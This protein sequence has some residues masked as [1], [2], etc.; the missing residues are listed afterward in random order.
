[1]TDTAAPATPRWSEYQPITQLVP[2]DRNAKDHDQPA[3][4]RSV[5]EFGFVE[6]VVVDERTGKL[7]A[8]HGRTEYLNALH[9]TGMPDDWPP[10]APWPPDGVVVTED[11]AWHVQVV[12]GVRSRDDAHAEAMGVAL[13]RVGELGGWKPDVLVDQLADL[14]DLGLLDA[15]GFDSDYL[16]DLIA[17]TT[18]PTLD[19]LQGKYGDPDPTQL[20]P[21][22]RF[23]VSPVDRDRYL[24]LVEGIEG[25]DDVLFAHLLGLAERP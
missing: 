9:A 25:G 1:M 13:N 6:P 8:G 16:D 19:E 10:D 23:K 17:Q 24:R 15:A 2:A 14:R 4:G 11:G 21:V 20:W 3:L 18:P 12:R 5:A 22:L 7:L